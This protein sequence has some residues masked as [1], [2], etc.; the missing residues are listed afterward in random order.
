MQHYLPS[1][2]VL[3]F[4]SW[5]LK[6]K[7]IDKIIWPQNQENFNMEEKWHFNIGKLEKNWGS[8]CKLWN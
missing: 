6:T 7:I 4:Q 2:I 8:R 1:H 3:E 5:K